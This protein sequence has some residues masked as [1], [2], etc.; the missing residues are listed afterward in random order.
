MGHL[1]RRLSNV[2]SLLCLLILAIGTAW[3]FN[4]A[5]RINAVAEGWYESASLTAET[6]ELQYP[7]RNRR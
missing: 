7:Y 1:T 2:T 5:T 6:A 4:F 3:I